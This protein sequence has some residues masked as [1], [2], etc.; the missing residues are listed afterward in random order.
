MR[1]QQVQNDKK[2]DKVVSDMLEHMKQSTTESIHSLRS[3]VSESTDKITQA[4]RIKLLLDSDWS[5]M[6]E[7]F[8]ANAQRTIEEY[9]HQTVLNNDASTNATSN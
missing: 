1:Q 9:F 4:M 5:N 3:I 2:R 7:A 6:S 8:R